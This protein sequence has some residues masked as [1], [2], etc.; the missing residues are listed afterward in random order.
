[1]SATVVRPGGDGTEPDPEHERPRVHRG[2][3]QQDHLQG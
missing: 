3:L 2:G 1:M